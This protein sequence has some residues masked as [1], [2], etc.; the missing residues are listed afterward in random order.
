MK[1]ISF[2]FCLWTQSLLAGPDDLKPPAL[3]WDD[4]VKTIPTK[5]Y[6]D[7]DGRIWTFRFHQSDAKL[8]ETLKAE[9]YYIKLVSKGVEKYDPA[10]TLFSAYEIWRKCGEN[11]WETLYHLA[12]YLLT[13][14]V[15]QKENKH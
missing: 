2:A 1:W 14:A 15:D 12:F 10:T 7:S 6:T 4:M 13:P 5:K 9:K 11:P 3:T 8:P